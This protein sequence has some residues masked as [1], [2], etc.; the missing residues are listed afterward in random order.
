M[1]N[2]LNSSIAQ[3]IFEASQFGYCPDV[4]QVI[5]SVNHQPFYLL[6][7]PH[8]CVKRAALVGLMLDYYNKPVLKAYT[9]DYT[10]WNWAAAEGF[11]LEDIFETEKL[12]DEVFTETPPHKIS[13][14]LV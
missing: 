9:I 7:R 8:T 2:Q 12:C 4:K 13:E 10:R 5:C 3:I 6:S 1:K 14:Y 11:N